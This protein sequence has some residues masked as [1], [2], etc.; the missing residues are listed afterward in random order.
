MGTMQKWFEM[1]AGFT[2]YERERY[3]FARAF[4]DRQPFDSAALHTPACWRRA[5]QVRRAPQ[6]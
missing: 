2:P 5:R 3:K 1:I 6:R 4:F